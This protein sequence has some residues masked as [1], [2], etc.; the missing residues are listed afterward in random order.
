MY[1][2]E[3]ICLCWNKV[4]PVEIFFFKA[5]PFKCFMSSINNSSIFVSYIEF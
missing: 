5:T 2:Y 1:E 4:Y 3:I